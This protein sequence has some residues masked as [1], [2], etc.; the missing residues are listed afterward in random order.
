MR[1]D[2]KRIVFVCYFK[3]ISVGQSVAI[4]TGYFQDSEMTAADG[5]ICNALYRSLPPPK[6]F[7]LL[8][9]KNILSIHVISILNVC[10][11]CQWCMHAGMVQK[12]VA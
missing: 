1:I 12:N 10:K 7:W 5:K 2:C 8:S 11:L 9:C 4:R 3:L 6:I